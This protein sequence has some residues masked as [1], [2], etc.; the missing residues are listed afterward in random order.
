MYTVAGVYGERMESYP[1]VEARNQLGRLVS[2]VQHGHEQIVI[3]EYGKPAAVLIPIG[4]LEELQRIRDQLDL[5][6]ARAIHEDPEAQWIPHD[7]VE[8]LLEAVDAEQRKSA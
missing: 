3:T 8:A 6:E 1:L 5:A 7:E 2:R 4:E